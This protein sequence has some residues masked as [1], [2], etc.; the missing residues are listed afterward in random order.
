MGSV[1]QGVAALAAVLAGL[2]AEDVLP[3]ALPAGLLLLAV[4]A[5]V[6]ERR[7]LVVRVAALAPGG[8]LVVTA[9]AE[10]TAGWARVLAFVA[11]VGAG[12]AAV[13]FDRHFSYLTFAAL[14]FSALGVYATVPD[15][16]QARALVGAL[17]PVALLAVFRRE[18]AEPASP[19]V[20]VALVAWVAIVGGQGRPGSVVGAL[21]CLGVLALGPLCRRSSPVLVAAVHVAVVVVASRV[22]GLRQSA[23]TAA[24][25]VA[26]VMILAVVLLAAGA[27][28]R[29]K[30][31]P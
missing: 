17:L 20:G 29:T 10:G 1:A 4:A 19:S 14:A 7:G 12:P 31:P 23:W 30:N 18:V 24:A 25:V 16:E 5:F 9:A 13:A 3:A 11:I 21:G 27:R 22:A 2:A 26:P 28:V 8:A 6:S 15:T